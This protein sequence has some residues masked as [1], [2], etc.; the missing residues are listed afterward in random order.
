MMSKNFYEIPSV[1][2]KDAGKK[3]V[4]LHVNSPQLLMIAMNL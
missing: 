2:S 4:T 1:E 3:C